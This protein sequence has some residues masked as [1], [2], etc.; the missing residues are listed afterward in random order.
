VNLPSCSTKFNAPSNLTTDWARRCKVGKKSK[1]DW[2]NHT[3]NG[4]RR[5]RRYG[6]QVSAYGLKDWLP[7]KHLAYFVSEVVEELDLSKIEAVY[8]KDLRGQPPYDP[9][10]MTKVLVY[11]YCVAFNYPQIGLAD[12]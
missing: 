1:T 6:K 7:E 10:M 2:R 9:R 5:N 3:E 4:R 11:G 12:S 8:E